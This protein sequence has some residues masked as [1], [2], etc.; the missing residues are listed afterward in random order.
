VEYGLTTSYGSS[1]TKNEFIYYHTITVG[2]L[3]PDT[4][5]HYRVRSKNTSGLEGVSADH[6][7]T[8]LTLM[9]ADIIIDNPAS[10]V[11]GTWT[12]GIVSTDE[13]GTNYLFRSTRG[14]GSNYVQYTPTIA[15]SGNYQ[16]YEWHPQGDK[17]ATDSP[18]VIQHQGGT[19][20]IPVNQTK[21]GG[22]WNFIGSYPLAAGT[23]GNVKITD[24][25]TSGLPGQIS[26][27]VMADA[28]KFVYVAP[29]P[30]PPTIITQP[31]H[32]NVNLGSTATFA[33]A[34]GGTAP[35]QF[36][37]C[38]NGSNIPG[39]TAGTYLKENA[40]RSDAG[41]YSVRITNSFGTVTSTN[42][43]LSIN[44]STS[45]LKHPQGEKVMP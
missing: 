12:N 10:T 19:Q 3:S 17:R 40:Q 28:I 23:N 24:A 26:T 5:Y 9:V 13:Y 41:V 6:V 29:P 36:Q 20:T 38:L 27:N 15:T 21:N 34:A 45:I 44:T 4:T 11:I 22:Q 1:V 31:Q 37:W 32:Q 42:A 33:V 18:H 16:I 25:Y 2:G 43:V 35:L 14:S 39:A 30:S 7:F 8:T